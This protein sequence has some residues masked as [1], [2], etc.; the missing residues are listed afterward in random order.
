MKWVSWGLLVGTL[1]SVSLAHA[2][3]PTGTAVEVPNLQLSSAFFQGAG[4]AAGNRNALALVLTAQTTSGRE[5][6]LDYGFT[7]GWIRLSE[8][9]GSGGHLT[10]ARVGNALAAGDYR[11]RLGWGFTGE[12]GLGL[13][14]GLSVTEPIPK[15]R[16]VRAALGHGIAMQGICDAWLWA[17]GRGGFV[18]PL[19]LLQHHRMGSWAGRASTEAIF[20]ATIPKGDEGETSLGQVFQ[21]GAEYAVLP[22]PWLAG[23]VRSHLVWMPRAVL[24]KGQWSV[25]PFLG[26][27]LGRWRIAG[28]LLVNIDE[29]YGFLDRGQRIWAASLKVGAWL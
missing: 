23:G 15:R 3:T 18:V 7:L 16:L 28:D 1:A 19:R 17:P 6:G 21:F 20:L 24:W 13:A 26:V 10:A 8:R 9:D 22:R 27:V 2:Q 14:L 12:V 25:S 4:E 5:E 29:P 11:W